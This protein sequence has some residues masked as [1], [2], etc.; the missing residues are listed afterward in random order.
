MSRVPSALCETRKGRE[1]RGKRSRAPT[2]DLRSSAVSVVAICSR[3][4]CYITDELRLFCSRSTCATRYRTRANL[5]RGFVRYDSAD[6][7]R[8]LLPIASLDAQQIY[9]YNKLTRARGSHVDIYVFA[10][11]LHNFVENIYICL[12]KEYKTA[13]TAA[14]RSAYAP[15]PPTYADSVARE[16]ERDRDAKEDLR[17]RSGTSVNGINTEMRQVLILRICACCTR[18]VE[19]TAYIKFCRGHFLRRPLPPRAAASTILLKVLYIISIKHSSYVSH[20]QLSRSWCGA[21]TRAYNI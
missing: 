4:T 21:L 18:R 8:H 14:P 16:N 19:T 9:K 2:A 11:E 3:L 20:R 6:R 7:T 10:G 12:V 15:P 1:R 17:C 5:Y 13:R